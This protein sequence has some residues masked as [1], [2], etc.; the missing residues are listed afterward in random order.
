MT[1]NI[2]LIELYCDWDELDEDAELTVN[3][4]L[5][6]MADAREDERKIIKKQEVKS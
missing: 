4:C 3:D 1:S 6:L 5:R 2:N